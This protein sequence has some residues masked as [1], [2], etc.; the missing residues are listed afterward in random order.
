M[1]L[2][3][4][5]ILACLFVTACMITS[6]LGDDTVEYEFS[7]DASITAL[8]IKDSIV[9]YYPGK[10]AAGKDTTLSFAVLGSDY[11]FI[12]N[13]NEG[14]I[15]NQDSL[16]VGTDISKVVLDITAD[17]YGIYIAA[18]TDSLWEETDSLDFN[19]PIHFKVIAENGIFG[20]PY[21]VMINV[22]QQDPEQ[23]TWQQVDG[24]F[25]T[26][27]QKQKAVYMNGSIYVF[28]EQTKQVAV[29]MAKTSDAKTWT[30]L[31]DINI[32]VK[33]DYSSVMVWGNQLYILADN[34]LYVSENGLEWTK[35][36]TTQTFSRL[37]ANVHSEYNQKI[38]GADVDNH[39]IESTDGINWTQYEALPNNFSTGHT[40]FVSYPLA[41]NPKIDRIVLAGDNPDKT[42]TTSVIWTQLNAE[43]CWAELYPTNASDA[44]PNFENTS[45][46]HYNDHLF[47]FGGI[48]QTSTSEFSPFYES[49]DNGITWQANNENI[50]FPED[51]N[52]LFKQSK[53]NYS[54]IVD[55]EQ[56]IWMMWS[57]TGKVWKGR[58]NKLGFKKQ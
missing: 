23:M 50:I 31:E 58:I 38:I 49:M 32:P 44:C 12:I 26:N 14:L 47:A 56:F 46:I 11:P 15:Y 7:K 2:R 27:I 8:S 37:L 30:P 1:K 45:I 22:H 25:P 55:E 21:K 5:N 57:K 35:S 43:N 18:E 10:T 53:G 28:A 34:E 52:T 17:T 54:Y 33:A 6:C 29:T 41:T 42:D 13:Q 20:K 40:A 24:N 36:E 9:T 4:L 39:Y 16:P 19:K 3:V 48:R 51:F